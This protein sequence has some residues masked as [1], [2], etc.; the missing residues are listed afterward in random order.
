ML[1]INRDEHSLKT[2]MDYLQVLEKSRIS[3]YSLQSYCG[4]SHGSSC[5]QVGCPITTA[6]E[7]IAGYT[8]L[9]L[10]FDFLVEFV[11]GKCMDVKKMSTICMQQSCKQLLPVKT[12]S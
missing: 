10:S 3:H 7:V 4:T 12:G 5:V 9:L 1:Y 2:S 11:T 8:S 6:S